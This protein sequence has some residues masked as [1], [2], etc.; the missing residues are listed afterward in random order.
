MISVVIPTYNRAGLLRRSVDSVLAQTVAD[1][2]VIIVDDASQDDTPRVAGEIGD[3]RVRYIRLEK[4]SGADAARNAGIEAAAGEYIAFQDSDDVWLPHKLET[5]LA[6]LRDT[7]ADVV[8]CAYNRYDVEGKL[9]WVYP[10]ANVK[11]GRIAYEQLL[12]G[13]LAS[14]Q[15]ILGKAACFKA[16]RFNPEFP[17]LQD[18]E[19]MLRVAR[20]YDVR[21]FSDV[22]VHMYEQ[23]DSI[24]KKPER[25]VWA[26]DKLW[27]MHR[28]AIERDPLI[29]ARLISIMEGPYS[30]CG[31]SIWRRCLGALS[32]KN[33]AKLNL[34]LIL[35]AGRNILRR[36]KK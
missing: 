19:L 12:P 2:E 14:T 13:N 35:G 16:E 32:L 36:R 31:L 7:G 27:A 25:A 5:Q 18:W 23:H 28:E 8:F 11:P 22:L 15:T 3:P 33:G 34:R 10:P 1:L 9:R 24:S 17:R 6:Q 29:Q 26:L 4:N 30:A 21:Y 20:R